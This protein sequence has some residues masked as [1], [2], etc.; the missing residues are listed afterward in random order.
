MKKPNQKKKDQAA[1]SAVLLM[2][3][4]Y[5]QEDPQ[6]VRTLGVLMLKWCLQNGWLLV[7]QLN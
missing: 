2:C 7:T 1:Q 6:G 3:E 5:E 4:G